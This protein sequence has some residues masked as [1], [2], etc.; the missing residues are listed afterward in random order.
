MK[1]FGHF[2]IAQES[3]LRTMAF[4]VTGLSCLSYLVMGAYITR[5]MSNMVFVFKRA[6]REQHFPLRLRD[7]DVYHS[8]AKAISDAAEAA[9]LSKKKN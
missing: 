9:G 5:Y 2:F 6:I 4:T 1:Q 8:F 3:I 7:S